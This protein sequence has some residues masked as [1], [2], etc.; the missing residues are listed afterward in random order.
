MLVSAGG[1]L[2]AVA[3]ATVLRVGAGGGPIDVSVRVTG[4]MV[5][6]SIIGMSRS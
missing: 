3:T 2:F 5:P 6:I 1:K 4:V